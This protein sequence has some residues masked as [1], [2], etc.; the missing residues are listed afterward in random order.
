LLLPLGLVAAG[1]HHAAGLVE[2]SVPFCVRRALLLVVVVVSRRL[3][4]SGS[5]PCWFVSS[6]ITG[7]VATLVARAVAEAS[8]P[9]GRW[10]AVQILVGSN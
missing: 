6:V 10:E 4:G 5:V 2:G 7:G 3:G 9:V 8:I 1:S